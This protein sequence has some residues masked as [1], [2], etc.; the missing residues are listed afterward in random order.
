[1]SED[2]PYPNIISLRDPDFGYGIWPWSRGP[3]WLTKG[4]HQFK[5][6][7]P[8]YGHMA[9]QIPDGYVFN[10]AS[11]PPIFWGPPCNYTPDGLCTIP[12]L[13]HDFLCDLLTGGSDWLK[14]VFHG[15]LPKA[16]PAPAVHEHFRLQLLRYGVRPT[17]ANTWG[18]LVALFGPKGKLRFR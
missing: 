18:K 7:T 12:A 2:L 13:E 3:Q 5:V 6:Q 9:F 8:G 16:P 4:P 14:S 17:K 11:T 15:E 1:M 10:K